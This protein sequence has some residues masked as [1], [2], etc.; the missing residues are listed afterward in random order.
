MF[1]DEA[2]WRLRSGDYRILYVVKSNPEEI[3]VL[4]IGHRKDVYR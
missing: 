1:G 2:V 3:I 4:D